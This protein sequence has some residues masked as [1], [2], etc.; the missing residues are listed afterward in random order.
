MTASSTGPTKIPTMPKART[1]PNTPA[2][3]SRSGRSAPLLMRTG[4][5]TLSIVTA[6]SENTSITVPRPVAPEV[7]SQIVAGATTSIGPSCAMQRTK[8]TAVR[9]SAWAPGRSR[10]RRPR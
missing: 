7:K 10:A 2:R 1:P 8:T 6:T 3:M 9:S 5:N 4:R